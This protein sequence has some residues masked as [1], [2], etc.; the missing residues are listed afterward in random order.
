M[1]NTAISVSGAF[2]YPDTS[3]THTATWN[4]GDG[5]TNV[6]DVTAG[7]VTESK[8]SGTIAGTHKYTAAGVYTLTLTVTATGGAASSSSTFQYIVIYNPSGG[9]AAGIGSIQAPIALGSKKLA[10]ADFVFL[11]KYNQGASAPTGIADFDLKAGAI[12]FDATSF[13]W[14]VVSKN[15]A[16]FYGT[17]TLAGSG[18][19]SFEVTAFDNNAGG[20]TPDQFEIQIWN[21]SKTLV[22][23]SGLDAVNV[24]GIVVS[25]QS[26]ALEAAGAS[27]IAPAAVPMLTQD[28]L[29]SVYQQAVGLWQAAG[30]SPTQVAAI[31]KITPQIADLPGQDLGIG[32]PGYVV[33]D[34]TAAGHGWITD[35]SKSLSDPAFAGEMDLLTVVSHELGHALGLDH[36][37]RPGDVMID[38]LPADT[39][40][41]PSPLDL[42]TSSTAIT[43][44]PNVASLSTTVGVPPFAGVGANQGYRTIQTTSGTYP[45]VVFNNT[46]SAGSVAGV[47][48]P[49]SSLGS[50]RGRP[51]RPTVSIGL[52]YVAQALKVDSARPRLRPSNPVREPSRSFG[53]TSSW[54][55]LEETKALKPGRD[56]ATPSILKPENSGATTI[57]TESPQPPA[58]I[59]LFYDDEAYVVPHGRL[60]PES[61]EGPLGLMGR[62]VAGQTFLEAL[63]RHGSFSELVALVRERSSAATLEK[64]W[65]AHSLNRPARRL[66]R[67]HEER[68]F[69]DDFAAEPPTRSLHLPF[70]LDARFAWARRRL[71]P[72]SF[73]LSGVTHTLCG[74]QAVRLLR[75]LIIEPFEPF[76]ALVCTSSAVV[77]MVKAITDSSLEYL[78]ERQGGAPRLDVRL[79]LIPLGVDAERFSPRSS[80]NVFNGAERWGSTTTK[81]SF[82]SSAARRITPRRIRF[83]SI[84]P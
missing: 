55:D 77:K 73:A 35:T 49:L 74:V 8:G 57:E 38:D 29:N 40:R 10:E 42:S 23:D 4:W 81:S 62:Q 83:R 37:G 25:A 69:H 45:A 22:Y 56:R 17:G 13:Q 2:T 39:R 12:D 1:I 75:D 52:K 54:A 60:R 9:F 26:N 6:P 61:P 53:P 31:E 68:H 46:P 78:K 11:T 59:G 18:K 34:A 67:I 43:T 84:A 44:G 21:T 70:P 48:L 47:D 19:Y 27:I 15:E 58:R 28:E 5:T 79:E 16:Q 51:V 80:P 82:C 66:L 72:G 64:I 3:D 63:L 24:G 7:K 76:D 14:L 65:R 20:H 71:A 30:A 50:N 32:G 36:S 33:I 41:V